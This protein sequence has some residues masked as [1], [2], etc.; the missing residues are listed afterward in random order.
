MEELY[1]N[2]YSEEFNNYLYDLHIKFL[3][4]NKPHE[5]IQHLNEIL[6]N[7]DSKDLYYIVFCSKHFATEYLKTKDLDVLKGIY[8]PDAIIYNTSKSDIEYT[9]Q[10]KTIFRQ[11]P[12]FNDSKFYQFDKKYDLFFNDIIKINFYYKN[13][14]YDQFIDH[15]KY[16][17]IIKTNISED[18]ILKNKNKI[19][20]YLKSTKNFQLINER[21]AYNLIKNRFI[22]FKL[23]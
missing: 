8:L 11:I 16:P 12:F 13:V 1:Q 3:V 2:L 18:F 5:A 20:E 7:S 10:Y 15:N 4:K 6:L 19:N 14:Y 9:I 21:K 17:R 22:N 23:K